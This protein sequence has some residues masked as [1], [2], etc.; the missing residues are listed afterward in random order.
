MR[1]LSFWPKSGPLPPR[2][3]GKRGKDQSRSVGPVRGIVVPGPHPPPPTLCRGR[4]RRGGGGA[5]AVEGAQHEP[6]GQAVLGEEDPLL[7]LRAA[8]DPPPRAGTRSTA[9]LRGEGSGE[10]GRGVSHG[11][12]LGRRG[13]DGGGLPPHGLTPPP[14]AYSSI[15]GTA[16]RARGIGRVP[17]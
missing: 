5:Y 11:G 15:A 4:T 3:V 12:S 8:A 14:G 13:E 2:K 9:L 1:R 6:P 17:A 7:H 10:G 16:A